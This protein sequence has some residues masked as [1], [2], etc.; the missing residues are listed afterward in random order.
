VFY[1]SVPGNLGETNVDT[2]V[3]SLQLSV[4]P[5]EAA[6]ASASATTTSPA[7]GDGNGDGNNP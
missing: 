1:V 7:P 5:Q 3:S 4:T 2:L 6:S